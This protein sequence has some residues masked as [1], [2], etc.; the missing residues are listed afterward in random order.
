MLRLIR[1]VLCT[2]VILACGIQVGNSVEAPSLEA[3]MTSV[4]NVITSQQPADALIATSSALFEWRGSPGYPDLAMRVIDAYRVLRPQVLAEEFMRRKEL[5]AGQFCGFMCFDNGLMAYALGSYQEAG[6]AFQATTTDPAYTDNPFPLLMRAKALLHQAPTKR[7]AERLAA[8]PA[9]ILTPTEELFPPQRVTLQDAVQSY[10]AVIAAVTGTFDAASLFRVRHE[11]AVDLLEQGYVEEGVE[12][13]KESRLSEY[14][15]E[16]A[17]ALEEL[18]LVAWDAN[19]QQAVETYRQDLEIL[20]PALQA[21]QELPF[22]VRRLDRIKEV[23]ERM[24][25]VQV[26]NRPMRMA[27]DKESTNLRFVRE[28]YQ[29][30]A[31]RMLPW[32]QEYPIE[33]NGSWDQSFRET[34]LTVHLFYHCSLQSL[35]RFAEAEAGLRGIVEAVTDSTPLSPVIQAWGWLANSVRDQGRIHEAQSAYELALTLD[36]DQAQEA[37]NKGLPV[38]CLQRYILRGIMPGWVR[39]THVANYECVV[40]ALSFGEGGE[41]R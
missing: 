7:E 17:S 27:M 37:V 28:D 24:R 21:R 4:E 25:G 13:L 20:L 39:A 10:T 2:S 26:G 38:D 34:A 35:G 3:A 36:T 14:P 29:G 11:Q 5:L 8:A 22:E 9:E 23:V 30:V 6:D 40:N 31:A 15:L 12:K 16:Q 18:L 33:Q 19:D 1:V 32:V 41:G